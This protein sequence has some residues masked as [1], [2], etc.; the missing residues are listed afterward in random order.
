MTNCMNEDPIF[1]D[2]EP[3][4]LTSTLGPNFSP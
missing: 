4:R 3:F 2:N 1:N